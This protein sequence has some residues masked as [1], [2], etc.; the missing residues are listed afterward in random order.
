VAVGGHAVE[1][2]RGDPQ[3]GVEAVEAVHHR[4]RRA[5]HRRRVHHQDH[6]R[7]QQLGHLRGG[8]ELPTA[9]LP[10]EQPHHALDHRD[11]GAMA[12]VGE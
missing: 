9:R 10:V 12:P 5:G 11:V 6:R 4:R 2:Q 8:R 3:L 1:H 7:A